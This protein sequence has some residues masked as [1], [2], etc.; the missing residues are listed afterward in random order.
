MYAPVY[1]TMFYGGIAININHWFS[2]KT[3]NE[4]QKTLLNSSLN[5]C[6]IHE[7]QEKKQKT[8]ISKTETTNS[9]RIFYVVSDY[10]EL[11]FSR[12]Y[13]LCSI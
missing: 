1:G 4:K 2:M 13:N 7:N 5:S 3:N 8:Y 11:D 9:I 6:S 12:S 10:K